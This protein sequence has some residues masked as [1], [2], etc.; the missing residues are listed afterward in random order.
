M[1]FIPFGLLAVTA[2]YCVVRG[3][4]L[5][6]ISIVGPVDYSLLIFA[7]LIGFLFLGE[8]P[9]F[10][11]VAGSIIITIGDITVAIV[12]SRPREHGSTSQA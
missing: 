7:R 3:S 8:Q 1:S 11:V 6:S 2:R 9:R 10:C 4:R 5:A 12:K